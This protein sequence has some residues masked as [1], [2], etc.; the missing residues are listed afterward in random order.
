MPRAL[1]A[2]AMLEPGLRAGPESPDPHVE[3][4]PLESGP[5]PAYALP[6]EDVP[7]RH[8][9]S[10]QAGLTGAE[11][12][13]RLARVGPNVI[14][15][16]E[17]ASA[18]AL[19]LHQFA[20]PVVYLLAAACALSLYFGDWHEATAVIAVLAVN[21][22]LGFFTELRAARS[23]EGLRA[24]GTR[25]AR[26]RRDGHVRVLAAEDLVPGDIVLIEGGDAVPA[27]LRLVE[28]SNLGADESTPR[29]S[30]YR[31]RSLWTRSPRTRAS[32]SA[33]RCCSAARWLF[34]GAEPVSS[35]Q[36]GL[37]L[38]SAGYRGSS[39][40]PRPTH[41]PLNADWSACQARWSGSSW[42]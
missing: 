20:S 23:V 35:S 16:K 21:T 37:E 12:R 17:R 41:R 11:A 24:L 7:R 2:C 15:T 39:S 36:R 22:G 26:A 13:H 31:W 18:L 9:T 8:R 42:R 6:V 14:A 1:T 30:P 40:K 32:P 38:N 25:S 29:G 10:L 3:S 5:E 4:G 34:A 33:R 19:L 27:D 28:T